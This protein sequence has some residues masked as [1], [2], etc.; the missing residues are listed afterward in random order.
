MRLGRIWGIE[1]RLDPLAFALLLLALVTGYGIELLLAC[2]ALLVHEAAHLAWAEAEGI[3]VAEIRVHPLGGRAEMP[4]LLFRDRRAVWATAFAGPVANLVMAGLFSTLLRHPLPTP[5]GVLL[6]DPQA[7]V[8]FVDANMALAALNLLP[9]L[10]LDGGQALRVTLSPVWGEGRTV[11]RLAL[12]GTALGMVLAA[13]GV[14]RSLRG[15]AAMNWILLGSWM[16]ISSR[17]EMRALPFRIAVGPVE[18]RVLL[19]RGKVLEGRV[20]VASRQAPVLTVYRRFSPRVYHVILVTDEGGAV[21]GFLDE[22][23]LERA[24]AEQGSEVTLEAFVR[25]LPG[26]GR[27]G[28]DGLTWRMV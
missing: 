14:M 17:G 10:P 24:L 23:D 7:T 20:L 3:A 25:P 1:I 8:F 4:D 11:R 19:A 15:E 27:V 9:V 18:R 2:L 21:I 6:P 16:A 22:S 5:W 28:P 13:Y 26:P 12:W